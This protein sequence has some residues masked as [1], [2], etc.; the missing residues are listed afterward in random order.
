MARNTMLNDMGKGT[1]F[2]FSSDFPR[3]FIEKSKSL[4]FQEICQGNDADYHGQG[5]QQI[6]FAIDGSNNNDQL[7]EEAIKG[8]NP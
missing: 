6:E 5:S 4:E 3:T 8:R 1:S 7:A 2:I